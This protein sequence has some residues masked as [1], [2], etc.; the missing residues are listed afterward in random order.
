MTD[1]TDP[2]QTPQAPLAETPQTP[3]AETQESEV[4]NIFDIG[5]ISSVL[6]LAA[7]PDSEVAKLTNDDTLAIKKKFG[8]GRIRAI[9]PQSRK[10]I[11][12]AASQSLGGSVKLIDEPVSEE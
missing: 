6:E 5:T 11:L 9:M 10:A 1:T 7:L 3:L 8:P 12:G 4:V 2:Q